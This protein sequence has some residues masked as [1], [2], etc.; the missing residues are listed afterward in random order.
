MHEVKMNNGIYFV[1]FKS[2]LAD[3]GSGTVVVSNEVVNG[4]DYGFS[5]TGK[6]EGERLTL[7][8]IQHDSSV[9]SVMGG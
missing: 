3:F 9:V 4:G 1:N 8:V 5:Y 2:N 7:R 6:V